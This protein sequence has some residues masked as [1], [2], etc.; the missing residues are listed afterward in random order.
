MPRAVLREEG[1]N[2]PRGFGPSLWRGPLNLS[3]RGEFACGDTRDRV[4]DQTRRSGIKLPDDEELN[5]ER[6]D[7]PRGAQGLA[8][9]SERRRCRTAQTW[10]RWVR[11]SFSFLPAEIASASTR[12]HT[13][14]LC[15]AGAWTYGDRSEDNLQAT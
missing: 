14:K 5:H 1:A 3:R 2:P 12:M 15:H 4:S 6:P 8:G 9:K 13:R 7:T 10:S 11:G